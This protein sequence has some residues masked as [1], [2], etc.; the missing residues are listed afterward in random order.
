VIPS[1]T[2]LRRLPAT[3]AALW[4]YGSLTCAEVLLALLGRRPPTRPA[5]AAGWR[6]APIR[7][8][9]YPGLVPGDAEVVG[10]LLTNLSPAEWSLLDRFEA[11]TYDLVPIRVEC[12]GAAADARTVT[13]E[14][15]TYRYGGPDA[16]CGSWDRERFTREQLAPY[17]ERT[18]R[19][20]KELTTDEGG[21]R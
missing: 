8:R 7:N 16:E 15:W 20:L 1:V 18:S 21:T 12:S 10:Q 14:A 13:L 19:W 9:P 17:L 11:P 4:V 5:K 3:P 2:A 6:V